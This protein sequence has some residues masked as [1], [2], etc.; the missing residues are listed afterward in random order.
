VPA[1]VSALIMVIT[2]SGDA[3]KSAVSPDGRHAL[4]T[5]TGIAM[6]RRPGEELPHAPPGRH[7]SPGVAATGAIP[8]FEHTFIRTQVRA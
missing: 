3:P 5:D 4:L 6:I 1:A 7:R 8:S 2:P